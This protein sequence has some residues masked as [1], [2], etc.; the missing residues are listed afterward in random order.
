MYVIRNFL[1]SILTM[2]SYTIMAQNKFNSGNFPDSNPAG[3]YRIIS[4]GDK[5]DFGSIETSARWNITNS[6]EGIGVTLNGSEINDYIFQYAGEYEIQFSVTKKHD[7]G[8]NHPTF[9]KKI[10]VKVN[11]VKLSFDFSK[12]G[13]S[14][15][16]RR[17]INYD[18]LIVSVPGKINI[19]GK[20]ANEVKAPELLITG[21]G[22]SLLAQPVNGTIEIKN[23]TQVF[24]YKIS[25]RVDKESYLMFDF[26]DFNDEVQSFNLQQ[27][28]N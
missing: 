20:T 8:C 15:K 16:I 27:I 14:Q 13:F 10:I 7:E 1:F 22:T 2:V 17:G 18:N 25:G 23:G 19:Q 24:K 5:I 9:S 3:Y 21:V 26:Y 4:F 12:I 28:I 11:P 6:K